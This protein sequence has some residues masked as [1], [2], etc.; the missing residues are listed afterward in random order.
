MRK[1]FENIKLAQP[2]ETK[3]AASLA[4]NTWEAPKGV[5][6]FFYKMKLP[7]LLLVL[8]I[9]GFSNSIF[10]QDLFTS[11]SHLEK[12]SNIRSA[13]KVLG[14]TEKAYVVAEKLAS[15]AAIGKNKRLALRLLDKSSLKPIGEKVY[16]E[17]KSLYSFNQFYY[18]N[19]WLNNNVVYVV[20]NNPSLSKVEIVRID[21]TSLEML[22]GTTTL[23]DYSELL[24]DFPKAQFN[25]DPEAFDRIDFKVVLSENEKFGSAV[26]YVKQKGQKTRVFGVQFNN[27]GE[28]TGNFKIDLNTQERVWERNSK[29]SVLNNGTSSLLYSPTSGNKNALIFGIG[30]DGTS[31]FQK[32]LKLKGE[33]PDQKGPVKV[34]LSMEVKENRFYIAGFDASG[35]GI[36]K[37]EYELSELLEGED[38]ELSF[39]PYDL[40]FVAKAKGGSHKT[41]DKRYEKLKI[42]T[43]SKDRAILNS[44]LAMN[45]EPLIEFNDDGELLLFGLNSFNNNIMAFKIAGNDIA[46]S[47]VI[48][49]SKSTWNELEFGLYTPKPI[50]LQN[51]VFFF[52]NGNASGYKFESL[53]TES[54]S[55]TLIALDMKTG[56]VLKDLYSIKFENSTVFLLYTSEFYK[57]NEREFLFPAMVDGK[58]NIGYSK[59]IIK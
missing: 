9:F 17:I 4:P 44:N 47:E 8:C 34:W 55:S 48:R 25:V 14:E 43:K 42:S 26:F 54:G 5:E 10:A 28:T 46:N 32:E 31:L 35:F 20:G 50:V 12:P 15:S 24:K 51:Q 7:F 2:T 52:L 19:A 38:L 22:S 56:A 27:K 30:N 1:S 21:A 40:M 36:L 3:F 33:I 6:M 59:V 49:F 37:G 53:G 41:V 13:V 16:E 39:M 45:V 57:I 29:F 23:I 11:K 18:V 58:F